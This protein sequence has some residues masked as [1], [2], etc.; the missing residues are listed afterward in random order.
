MNAPSPSGS[1]EVGLQAHL[2]GQ[3]A[4]PDGAN[5]VTTMATFVSSFDMS[6]P[7]KCGGSFD[8]DSLFVCLRANWATFRRERSVFGSKLGDFL[9]TPNAVVA[10]YF[11]LYGEFTFVA[12]WKP[13]NCK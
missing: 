12:R 7:Q 4:P 5:D 11:S 9:W 6:D 1:G 2:N 3:K 8:E 10:S 13:R